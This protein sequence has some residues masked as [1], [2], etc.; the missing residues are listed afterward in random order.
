[1]ILYSAPWCAPCRSVKKNLEAS[2]LSYSVIDLEESPEAF[3][4]A[5]IKA[6]PTL[7]CFD[8]TGKESYRHTGYISLKD[9]LAL[10]DGNR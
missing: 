4:T 6:I 7:V 9:L 3:E 5:G 1:M 2:E 8:D 10:P